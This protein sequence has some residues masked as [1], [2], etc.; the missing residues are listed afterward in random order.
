MKIN[1]MTTDEIEGV[2]LKTNGSIDTSDLP[3]KAFPTG[4]LNPYKVNIERG[5]AKLCKF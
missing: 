5:D 3:S 2:F 1:K 4:A